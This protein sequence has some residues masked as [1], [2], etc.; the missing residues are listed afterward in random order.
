MFYNQDVIILNFIK[1]E[2]EKP[3]RYFKKMVRQELDSL[4]CR[5]NTVQSLWPYKTVHHPDEKKI[6][7][8]FFKDF[9]KA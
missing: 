6:I 5:F 8:I 2:L 9:G 4:A 3:D 1:I 7:N